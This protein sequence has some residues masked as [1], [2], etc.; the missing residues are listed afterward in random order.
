MSQL[1]RDAVKRALA[2]AGEVGGG[3]IDAVDMER[4]RAVY[5]EKEFRPC[6]RSSACSFWK[7]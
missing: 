1:K 2:D 7:S 3:T 4:I 5:A 6:A